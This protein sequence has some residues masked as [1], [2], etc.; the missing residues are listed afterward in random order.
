M[1]TSTDAE[2]S[3][4]ILPLFENK[5]N[6]LI[7]GFESPLTSGRSIVLVWGANS[8]LLNEMVSALQGNENYYGNVLGA[9]SLLKNKQVIPLISTQTYFTGHLP[10]YE[11]LQWIMSRNIILFL[12]FSLVSVLLMTLLVYY[13]LK[14]KENKRLGK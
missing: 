10:W 5:N 6:A 14:T 4:S 1:F 9:L 3:H 12:L 11:Y 8:N 13:V 2:E 7:A